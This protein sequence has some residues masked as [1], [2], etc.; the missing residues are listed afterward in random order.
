MFKVAG[1]AAAP[2]ANQVGLSHIALVVENLDAV[3]AMYRKLKAHDVPIVRAVDHGVTQSVY[4]KDPE[5]NE[6]EIYCDVAEKPWRQVDTMIKA[7]PLEL[8]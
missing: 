5:G 6:L 7:D 3:K 4:F 2:E 1:D 8:D